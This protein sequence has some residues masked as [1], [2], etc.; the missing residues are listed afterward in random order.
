MQIKSFLIRATA[1]AA[2]AL[3]ISSAAHAQSASCGIVGSSTAASTVYDP[4][5]PIGLQ[6]TTLTLDLTRVNNSGGGN[7][8]IVN[9]YLKSRGTNAD[10]TSIVPISVTGSVAFEGL[11][12]NIFHNFN[13]PAPIVS[14]SSLTPTATQRFLKIN[15]TGNNAASN[16]AT[17]VFQVRLPQN[18]DLNTSA[19]LAFDAYF[20]CSIQGGTSSG[21]EQIGSFNNA[22]VF[23]IKVLSALQATYAGSALDFG[24]VGD[25][26]TTEVVAAPG[27]YTT[28]I[29]NHVRVRSSGPYS[30]SLASDNNYKLTF[31]GGNLGTTTNVLKYNVRFLGQ[32]RSAANPTFNT[33]TCLRAGVPT[34][35][36]DILPVTAT[37]LEGGVGKLVSPTYRDNLTVTVT[38]LLLGAPSQQSCPAL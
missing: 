38:P 20:G 30:V 8:R 6:P 32:V 15:F 36:A 12:Q 33:V 29:A 23:P 19:S 7:T 10:G 3:G 1:V 31:P 18:L 24:E 17:V 9:F 35:E 11:N 13:A 5:A 4:F 25:K 37:L 14:P 27:V 21:L 22:V 28:A 34:A 26:T 2:A 16:T